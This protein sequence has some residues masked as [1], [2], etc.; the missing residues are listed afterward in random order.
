MLLNFMLWQ[1]HSFIPDISIAPLQVHYYS[2]ALQTIALILFKFWVNM[3]KCYVLATMSEGLAQG[4]YMVARVGFEPAT[5]WT[6]APNLPLSHHAPHIL[7]I[8]RF[9]E[10]LCVCV[11]FETMGRTK[12]CANMLC[13]SCVSHCTIQSNWSGMSLYWWRH[14]WPVSYTLLWRYN[15]ITAVF[16]LLFWKFTWIM[17]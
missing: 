13:F 14:T 6:Q 3:L 10:C 1:R 12:C 5:F 8:D 11:H 17:L 9:F 15:G 7:C 2:E 4:P 16:L